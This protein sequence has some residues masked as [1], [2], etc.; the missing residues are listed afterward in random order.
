M[1]VR[2]NLKKLGKNIWIKKLFDYFTVKYIFMT[3]LSIKMSTRLAA[4]VLFFALFFSPPAAQKVNAQ[5][6]SVVDDIL[7]A[8]EPPEV[9]LCRCHTA[10]DNQ[11]LGGNVISLRRRCGNGEGCAPGGPC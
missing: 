9:G 2:I 8:L 6:Y 10:G 1:T 7:E 3:R 4:I 11:C 5:W